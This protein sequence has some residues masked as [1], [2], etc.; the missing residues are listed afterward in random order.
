MMKIRRLLFMI[1]A[2]FLLV[3][4]IPSDTFGKEINLSEESGICGEN[5]TWKLEAQ[6][7]LVI[8][9]T[10]KMQDYTY[11]SEMPWYS[12][13]NDIKEVVLEEGVTTIGD[14]A[15]YGM[16]NLTSI[17][18]PESVVWIGK[19]S[20]K[21]SIALNEVIL[22]SGL[23]QLGESAFYGC[24]SLSAIDIPAS[25]YTVRPYTFKNCTSLTSVTFHE[26]NLQKLSDSSFY[27]TALRKVEIPDC[28]TIVDEYCFKNCKNLISVKLS[29]NMT[30]IREAVFYGTALSGVDIPEGIK[31]IGPYAFKNCSKLLRAGLPST[32]TSIEESSFYACAAL[33]N[34]V[35]PDKVTT[36]GDYAFRGCEKLALVTFSEYLDTIGESAFYGCTALKK[37]D[38]PGNVKTI[39]GYAF[40]GCTGVI[41][42]NLPNSLEIIGES[43]F[44]GCNC[45][46]NIVIPA[47]VTNVGA[48]AFSRCGL[49]RE[50]QF[51]GNAPS[52]GEYAFSKIAA[53]VYCPIDNATW[54][55]A[56]MQNYGGA[57]NW[58]AECYTYQI[59]YESSN[60]TDLGNAMA[61][62]RY[63]TVN[64]ILAPAREGYITP[65]AQ[66]VSWDSTDTKIIRF[67]Y[68][69]EIVYVSQE[70]TYDD[71]CI[72]DDEYGI[73]YTVYAEYQNRTADSVEIRLIWFN[74]I[75]AGREY[76][77]C[78][79]GYAQYFTAE[80]AGQVCEE[81]QIADSDLW[82][83]TIYYLQTATA[84]TDWITIP[85]SS[86]QTTIA[87]G[88]SYRDL[89]GISGSWK[90]EMKIP[91]Y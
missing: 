83:S 13:I 8:S 36:V 67:T 29:A 62:Y 35:L 53:T 22:P 51:A 59:V 50:I 1:V 21:N 42:V 56:V 44:Y 72:W 17:K 40:K 24:T 87:V 79:Y 61:G 49:L 58:L 47:S 88:A 4:M 34:L 31:K 12:Y 60:G 68:V 19:Y 23:T 78:E 76:S 71:W 20:F 52:I 48:Y 55:S 65:E 90:T 27:G 15:F 85:V 3:P 39:K 37:L 63:G 14:Y 89:N 69:P 7:L 18:I 43:A 25:L 11:K 66:V 77:G 82:S 10:G 26:G 5:L 81:V 54:T 2:I 46:G 32:L 70:M 91:V 6:N 80:I 41:E 33:R 57:I 9:G 38:I 45:L 64:T 84:E 86:T 74:T 28:T 73:T 16:T 30:E 75:N